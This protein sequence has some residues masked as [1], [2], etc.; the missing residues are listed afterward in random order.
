MVEALF[1]FVRVGYECKSDESVVMGHV[2]A[3]NVSKA[4]RAKTLA[5]RCLSLLGTLY[6]FGL[7]SSGVDCFSS[8]P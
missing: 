5:S 6:R 4:N 8:Q 3:Q 7:S 1:G 2:K